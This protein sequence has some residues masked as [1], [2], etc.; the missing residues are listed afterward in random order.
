MAINEKQLVGLQRA[1]FAKASRLRLHVL[2]AQL[3]IASVSVFAV[4]VVSAVYFAALITALASLYW[5][6]NWAEHRRSRA[7]AERARR[8]TLL[9]EGLGETVSPTELSDLEASFSV[10]PEEGAALEDDN[11]YDTLAAPGRG[12]LTEMLEHA[13]FFSYNLSKASGRF[14]VVAF[15]GAIVATILVVFAIV[16]FA[17]NELIIGLIRGFCA[18]LTFLVSIDMLGAAHGYFTAA[19][20]LS[21]L[22][23][24]LESIRARGYPLADLLLAL[25]DYNSAVESAPMFVPGVYE[26]NRDRFNELWGRRTARSAQ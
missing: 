12:R 26:A 14:S 11:Y 23:A 10:S 2:G 16:P 24:R 9:M 15:L 18:V 20:D 8:A 21:K 13:C 6:Y 3:V 17:E 7:Q 4:F 19:H 25:C 5:L 22:Q 1:E